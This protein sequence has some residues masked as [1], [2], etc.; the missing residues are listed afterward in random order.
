MPYFQR[1]AKAGDPL[2]EVVIHAPEQIIRAYRGPKGVLIAHVTKGSS[3]KTL[4]RKGFRSV[5]ENAP[6]APKAPEVKVKVS[7]A[8]QVAK[9]SVSKAKPSVSKAKASVSKAKPSASKAKPSVSKFKAIALLV[10][11][12][13]AIGEALATG[14]YDSFLPD[15]LKAE[16]ADKARKGAIEA[17]VGRQANK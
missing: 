15:M 11:P 4:V 16:N 5:G 17:I 10:N 9:P 13:G 7:K 14:M 6:D 1:P 2:G 12:I 8:P 3:I